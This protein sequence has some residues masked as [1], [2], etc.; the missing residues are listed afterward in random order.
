M[1]KMKNK[2]RACT[3]GR[4]KYS[5]FASLAIALL[6]V[7][8]IEA[9]ARTAKPQQEKVQQIADNGQYTPDAK[10]IYSVC[11]EQ[12]EFPGGMME[13]MKFLAKNIKYPV[14]C[15]KQGIQGRIIVQ[16]IVDKNGKVRK[17]K[18]VHGAH[19]DLNKEALRVTRLMPKWKPGKVKGENVTCRFT[20][21]ITFSLR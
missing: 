1:E 12:P 6:W 21:P 19:P 16:F 5:L 17:P 15:M 8:N 13:C 20:I 7:S 11:E 3:A 4:I 10:G 9:A 18:V 14:E 2:K